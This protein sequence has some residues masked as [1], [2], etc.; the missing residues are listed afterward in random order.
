[1]PFSSRADE[2]SHPE[3]ALQQAD[4]ASHQLSVLW[5]A[6][7]Q[8]K[9][10][11]QPLPA[12]VAAGG[13]LHVSLKA[14]T[15]L[16][17][18]LSTALHHVTAAAAAAATTAAGAGAEAHVPPHEAEHLQR[19]VVTRDGVPML[20]GHLLYWLQQQPRSFTLQQH[21]E[22]AAAAGE[23]VS[24]CGMWLAYMQCVQ[25]LASMVTAFSAYGLAAGECSMR[26]LT[27][28]LG[29]AGWLGGH[30]DCG[31]VYAADA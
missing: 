16:L 23:L 11:K 4:E 26:H 19:A 8:R 30:D 3:A 5:A 12:R 17:L 24:C 31:V 22:A 25:A 1:M 21:D 20:L 18:Q 13:A 10:V 15:R 28:V 27:T 2:R 7:L 6:D 29:G 14:T 9:L